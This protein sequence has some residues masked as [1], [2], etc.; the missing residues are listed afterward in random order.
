MK[1]DSRQLF[2]IVCF[3]IFQNFIDTIMSNDLEIV[4]A[5]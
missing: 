3:V 5:G 1:D 4:P 2:W